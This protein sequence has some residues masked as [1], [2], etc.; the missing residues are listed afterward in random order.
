[1]SRALLVESGPT[2]A[3]A[4]ADSLSEYG[5]DATLGVIPKGPYVIA[6]LA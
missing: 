1:M 4:V 6:E 3:A 5:P 2:V